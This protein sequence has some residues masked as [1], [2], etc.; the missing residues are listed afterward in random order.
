MPRL[1]TLRRTHRAHGWNRGR[2]LHEWRRVVGGADGNRPGG[3]AAHWPPWCRL[4]CR[5]PAAGEAVLEAIKRACS[6][7]E[8]AGVSVNTL[9][10]PGAPLE[11]TRL[12]SVIRLTRARDIF[13]PHYYAL[14]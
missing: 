6:T 13:I 2:L 7:W 10:H 9:T 3:S 11:R 5:A 4:S 8:Q 12:R 14:A 1:R